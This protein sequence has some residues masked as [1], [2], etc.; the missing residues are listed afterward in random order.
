[1]LDSLFV[2]LLLALLPL[3][4]VTSVEEGTIG[5]PSKVNEIL[6]ALKLPKQGSSVERFQLVEDDV[7]AW[8]ELVVDQRKPAGVTAIKLDFR[9]EN[10]LVAT[11]TIDVDQIDLEQYSAGFLKSVLKGTQDLYAEGTLKVEGG[12]A[13][14]SIDKATMN[15]WNLPPQLVT[16]MISYLST[17]QSPSV[18]ITEPF[19]LPYGITG[20]MT[21]EDAVLITR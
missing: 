1:M 10:H 12:Q 17:K 21:T 7:N 3:S 6:I 16:T 9:T 14:F 15:G 18:D 13:T 5:N 20:I 19:D 2:G 11:A 8:V 4:G